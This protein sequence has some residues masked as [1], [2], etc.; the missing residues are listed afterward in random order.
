MWGPGEYGHVGAGMGQR[1]LRLSLSS[2]SLFIGD[3]AQLMATN[4]LKD[5]L[6]PD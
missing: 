2:P 5:T 4:S 6:T 3:E 1:D